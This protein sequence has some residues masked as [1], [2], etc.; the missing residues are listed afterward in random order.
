MSIIDTAKH[1]PVAT[2]AVVVVGL[3]AV[4]LVFVRSSGGSSAQ[5]DAQSAG[6]LAAYYGAEAAQTQA[7]NELGIVQAQVAG[8]QGLAT[9]QGNTAT[10]LASIQGNT[11]ATLANIQ[12][13]QADK[14]LAQTGINNLAATTQSGINAVALTEA[15]GTEA[16]FNSLVNGQTSQVNTSTTANQNEFIAYLDALGA[17]NGSLA[18][19]Y[20]GVTQPLVTEFLPASGGGYT[21]VLVGG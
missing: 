15:G 16:A 7:A 20:A 18:G 1:H 2:G 17:N 11:S 10:Q 3:L 12:G 13:N 9:I 14:L 5:P 4:Y 8:Q 6:N 21:P 19:G